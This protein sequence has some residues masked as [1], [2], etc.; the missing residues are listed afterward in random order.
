MD[1]DT[2]NMLLNE[3]G[4]IWKKQD[5][6]FRKAVPADCRLAIFLFWMATGLHFTAVA[7]IFYVGEATVSDITRVL[8]ATFR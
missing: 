3:Y 6:Y 2:F 5:T 1:H 8:T 7:E 4:D